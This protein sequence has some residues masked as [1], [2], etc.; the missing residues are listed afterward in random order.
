MLNLNK[1]WSQIGIR[2]SGTRKCSQRYEI[3]HFCQGNI[4]AIQASVIQY[5]N[6]RFYRSNVR[7]TDDTKLKLK[8]FSELEVCMINFV[9]EFDTS[10][11][12]S[13]ALD[14]CVQLTKSNKLT[15]PVIQSNQIKYINQFIQSNQIKSINHFK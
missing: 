14:K 13:S 1:I 5:G 12:I 3:D 6:L 9:I 2:C 7:Y 8:K 4:S 10:S 11:S 15:N